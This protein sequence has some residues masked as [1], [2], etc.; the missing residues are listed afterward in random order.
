MD[1]EG[2]NV[3]LMEKA[4]ARLRPTQNAETGEQTKA[5]EE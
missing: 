2:R 5:R 4:I 3:L 1:Y